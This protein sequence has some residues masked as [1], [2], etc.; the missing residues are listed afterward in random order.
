MRPLRILVLS[1]FPPA[2]GG[3][4]LQTLLQLKEMARR[5]HTVTVVDLNPHHTGPSWDDVEGLPVKRIR[6]PRMP[7]LRAV[8]YH[9]TLMWCTHRLCRSCDLVQVNHISPAL[10]SALPALRLRRK[11]SVVVAWGSAAPG[12]GPF[13]PGLKWR[14]ARWCASRFDRCVA[15]ATVT[16]SHLEKSG[17]ASHR[18]VFVPNGVDT[19]RFSP[20]LD[21]ASAAVATSPFLA[22]PVFVTTGRLVPAKGLDVLLTAWATVVERG[23]PGTLAIIGDGHLRV[24]LEQQVASLGLTNRVAMLGA[25]RDVPS[26]LRSADAYVSSSRTEGMSNALLEALSS[27]LPI[28]ATRVGAAADIIEDR[29]SGLLVRPN[30]FSALAAAM[31]EIIGDFQ[32]RQRLATAARDRA[33]AAFSI[34]AVVAR[35][36]ELYRQLASKM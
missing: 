24:N 17:F 33:I 4:E 32:L 9:A 11:P 35:Y 29:V 5:G 22:A 16:L 18:L 12:I 8:V 31:E 19:Q 20:R 34:G 3:G 14:L 13:G 25:R 21:T 27:G 36:L 30:D 6:T 23:H 1:S 28:V 15:L 7:F 26:L 2:L 10:V